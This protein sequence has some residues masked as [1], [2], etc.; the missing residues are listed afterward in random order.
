[1]KHIYFRTT[2][3]STAFIVLLTI[4]ASIAN[5]KT[6]QPLVIVAEKSGNKTTYAVNSILTTLPQMID[7]I[8]EQLTSQNIRHAKAF[9][10]AQDTVNLEEISNLTGLI[11][12]IGISNI[13]Y[14]NFSSDKRHMVELKFVGTSIPFSDDP[15]V[16]SK[17][18]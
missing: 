14:F 2:I 12:K 3:L 4:C 7:R 1:M 6:P 11:Q 18:K 15:N 17:A 5:A 10:L 9:V 16:L 8:D 13:R